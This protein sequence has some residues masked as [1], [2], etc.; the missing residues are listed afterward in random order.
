MGW[1]VQLPSVKERKKPQ[2]LSKRIA[3]FKVIL[4]AA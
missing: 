2:W 1:A 3:V 4:P